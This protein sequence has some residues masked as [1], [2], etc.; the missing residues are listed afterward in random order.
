MP[1]PWPQQVEEVVTSA[2]MLARARGRI[3][4]VR[5]GV[6]RDIAIE[7]VVAMLRS[8]LAACGH[9]GSEV[10]TL[11]ATGPMRLISAEFER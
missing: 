11:L 8:R 1:V 2:L 3:A 9:P 6:P 10:V 7:P 5:V 4:A